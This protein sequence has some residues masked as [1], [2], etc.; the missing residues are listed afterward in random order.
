M[1]ILSV[2]PRAHALQQEKLPQ[3][4]AHV[5]Q[6]EKACVQQQRL[7]TGKELKKLNYTVNHVNTHL[8]KKENRCV[9]IKKKLL[10]SVASLVAEHRL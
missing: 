2:H 7:S 1:Q 9:K 4:E 8:P 5:T 10:I 3:G 6:L